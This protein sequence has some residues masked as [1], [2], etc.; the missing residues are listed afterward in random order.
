M[1][2]TPLL[3]LFKRIVY[4]LK[5]LELSK[6]KSC[7]DWFVRR[8]YLT[9]GLNHLLIKRYLFKP[10]KN[11]IF[12]CEF[13]DVFRLKFYIIVLF[14]IGWSWAVFCISGLINSFCNIKPSC[15]KRNVQKTKGDF[16]AIL[17]GQSCFGAK[18]LI[19]QEL[20]P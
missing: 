8:R 10:L 9:F 11:Y 18:L 4:F 7:V 12:C 20:Q 15:W 5:F 14:I 2:K 13:F 16:P 17:K 19:T 6:I 3:V 1:K